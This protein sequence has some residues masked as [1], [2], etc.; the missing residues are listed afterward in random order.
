M[1]LNAIAP[2]EGGSSQ[3]NAAPTQLGNDLSNVKPEPAADSR[4][5]LVKSTK[6]SQ[7]AQST[8]EVRSKEASKDEPLPG[9]HQ[10]LQKVACQSAEGSD[11]P[12]SSQPGSNILQSPAEQQGTVPASEPL[13]NRR[14]PGSDSSHNLEPADLLPEEQREAKL[15]PGHQEVDSPGTQTQLGPSTTAVEISTQHRHGTLPKLAVEDDPLSA[16]LARAHL[17]TISETGTPENDLTEPQALSP[18]PPSAAD[19]PQKGHEGIN[20]LHNAPDTRTSK[21]GTTISNSSKSSG[22]N[23][24]P[25]HLDVG[26]DQPETGSMDVT[27]SAK[28]FGLPNPAFGHSPKT[29]GIPPIQSSGTAAAELLATVLSGNTL[30]PAGAPTE[31]E[32]RRERAEDSKDAPEAMASH[33]PTP[34]SASSYEKSSNYGDELSQD[35]SRPVLP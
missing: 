4:T 14:N 27:T 32:I 17:R 19:L 6:H 25:I 21:G 28:Y 15:V 26:H 12:A 20:L 31:H 9:Q 22:Q 13:G 16:S 2:A 23:G 34:G 11:H 30:A 18:S 3:E 1:I 7:P 35:S 29:E 24:P 10:Q 5:P 33:M 8:S